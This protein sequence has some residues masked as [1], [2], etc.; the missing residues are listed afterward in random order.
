[1]VISTFDDFIDYNQ[2]TLIYKLKLF[3]TVMIIKNNASTLKITPTIFLCL[4]FLFLSS[5]SALN[6]VASSHQNWPMHSGNALHSGFTDNYPPENTEVVWTFD[7]GDMRLYAPPVVY[8]GVVY[9]LGPSLFAMNASTGEQLWAYPTE[10][11]SAFELT[12]KTN[13]HYWSEWSTPAISGDRIYIVSSLDNMVLALDR[14][15]EDGVDEGDVDLPNSNYD[16]IWEWPVENENLFGSRSSPLVVGD[17]VYVGTAEGDLIALA[18]DPKGT[19]GKSTGVPELLWSYH[20]GTRIDSSPAYHDDMIFI[21]TWDIRNRPGAYEFNESDTYFYAFDATPAEDSVDEGLSDS[22]GADYDVIWR[23]KLGDLIWSSPSINPETGLVYIGCSDWNLYAF[24]YKTGTKVWSY[25]VG[26][27]VYS[28]P[29]Y[30][31]DTVVFGTT[32]PDNTLYAL[33]ATNGAF[34][35]KYEAEEKVAASPVITDGIVYSVVMNGRIHA[36]DLK[37]SSDG[38]TSTI[39]TTVLPNR[40]RSTPAISYGHMYITCWDGNVYCMG[41]VPE[42]ELVITAF[43]IRGH[44]SEAIFEFGILNKGHGRIINGTVNFYD[45]NTLIHSE[46]VEGFIYQTIWWISFTAEDLEAREHLFKIELVYLDEFGEERIFKDYRLET[47]EKHDI[48]SF[49]PAPG[50]IAVIIIFI[51][52]AVLSRFAAVRRQKEYE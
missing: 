21:G 44:S 48:A 34:K 31:D 18:A 19:D 52:T 22:A 50:L 12:N 2:V 28:T 6:A 27:P 40:I 9:A 7:T 15:P 38:T 13:W 24:D 39:W 4:L 45:D 46:D 11:G 17:T 16:V 47:I 41:E 49:I 5:I 1:L 14:T 25:S 26:G 23:A 29:A 33:N 8:D 42:V 32:E 35:W 3:A 43:T 36:F 10:M 30:H 20:I 37:G 51:L